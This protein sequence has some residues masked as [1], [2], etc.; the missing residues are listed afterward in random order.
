MRK[1]FSLWAVFAA[2]SALLLLSSVGMGAHPIYRMAL[3]A[4]SLCW[5]GCYAW[6][7]AIRES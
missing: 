3:M 2:L 5:C 6:T 4:A 7:G 1:T